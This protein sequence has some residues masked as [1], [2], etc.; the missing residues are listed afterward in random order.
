MWPDQA[1]TMQ[2][3]LF[4]SDRSIIRTEISE[5]KLVRITRVECTEL[6]LSDLKYYGVMCAHMSGLSFISC[7]CPGH[8]CGSDHSQGALRKANYTGAL[9]WLYRRDVRQVILDVLI[10]LEIASHR[11]VTIIYSILN[12]VSRINAHPHKSL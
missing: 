4:N 9:Q 5:V 7:Q 11:L 3:T 8:L 12:S 2:I 10:Q 6:L 1:F